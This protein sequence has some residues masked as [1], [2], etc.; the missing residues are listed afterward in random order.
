D[1]RAGV[2]I[3]Q[4]AA[5]HLGQETQLPSLE[6]GLEVTDLA[7]ACDVGFSCAYVNTLCWSSPTRPLPMENNPR[8]VFERLFGDSDSTD[9]SARRARML[10]DRSILDS[11]TEKVSDLRRDLGPGD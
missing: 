1:F 2:S 6:L 4:I 11:L 9:G 5:N 10:R 8:A 3:D 7:G